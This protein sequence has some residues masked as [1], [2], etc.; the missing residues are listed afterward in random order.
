MH[1]M[2][3]VKMAAPGRLRTGRS[4]DEALH[5][6][7]GAASGE[8]MESRKANLNVVRQGNTQTASR[9]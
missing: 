5:L 7:P 1:M 8:T 9:V 3:L 6:A 4:K 2:T